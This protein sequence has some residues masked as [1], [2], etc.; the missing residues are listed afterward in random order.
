MVSR[1]TRSWQFWM[2]LAIIWTL[3]TAASA[4][5]DLPRAAHIAHDPEFMN[6]LTPESSA[7][8]RGA[9]AAQQ[10]APGAPLW[11]EAPRVFRMSNG[12]QLDFPAIT[13]DERAAIVE[14]EYHGLLQARASGQHWLYLLERVALWLAPLLLAGLALGLL[15]GASSRFSRHDSAS[16][17]GL[18]GTRQVF[19]HAVLPEVF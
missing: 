6:Q 12:K 13:T 11:S 15:R 2:T 3:A 18:N 1:I 14:R 5:L 16:L 4:W 8:V 19:F 7:I 10:S 9:A 17:N